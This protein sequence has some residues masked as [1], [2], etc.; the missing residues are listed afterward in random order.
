[1]F[2]DLQIVFMKKA[3]KDCGKVSVEVERAESDNNDERTPLL[4]R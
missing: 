2:V 3:E 1:M 4:D